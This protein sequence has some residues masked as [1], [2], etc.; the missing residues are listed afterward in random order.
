[1]YMIII[2]YSKTFIVIN[3]KMFRLEYLHTNLAFLDRKEIRH[4][5]NIN[6]FNLTSSK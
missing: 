2:N 6:I 3:N 4:A 1:M 5:T